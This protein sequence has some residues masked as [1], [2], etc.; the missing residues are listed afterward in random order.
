VTIFEVFPTSSAGLASGV[1]SFSTGRAFGASFD[2][3]I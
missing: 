2:I 3:T 1:F